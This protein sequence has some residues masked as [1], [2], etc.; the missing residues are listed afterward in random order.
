MKDAFLFKA[1]ENL[2]VAE[3]SYANGHFNACAN[4]AY[5]AAFQAAVAVLAHFGL[6]RSSERIEH[7]AI[8]GSFAT[9]LIH[10][11]KIFPNYLKSYLP[12]LQEVRDDADYD[13]QLLSKSEATKQ[14]RKAK[15]FINLLVEEIQK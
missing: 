3:W 2:A 5:Y 14:L 13:A 9:G 10:Q 11:R 7:R 4:R 6:L 1:Q 12:A 15:E 8:Q